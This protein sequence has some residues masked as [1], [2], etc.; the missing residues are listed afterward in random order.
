MNMTEL[1]N[2][3]EQL[4]SDI[5]ALIG[6]CIDYQ[7]SKDYS[8]FKQ[9]VLILECILDDISTDCDT[10]MMVTSKSCNR[11]FEI[12]IDSDNRLCC[13]ICAMIENHCTDIVFNW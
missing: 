12:V 9:L 13:D 1:N 7:K 3:Y 6:S 8:S 5:N 10:P 2:C 4:I 11:I